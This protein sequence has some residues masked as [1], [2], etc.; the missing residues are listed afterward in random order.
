MAKEELLGRV[1][2]YLQPF[3]NSSVGDEHQ[4][5]IACS[6]N[7]FSRDMQEI[8]DGIQPVKM[9]RLGGAGNKVTRIVLG[10]VDSYM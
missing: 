6:L 4:V 10:E 9:V 2:T 3:E 8:V 1:P 7:H 5:R